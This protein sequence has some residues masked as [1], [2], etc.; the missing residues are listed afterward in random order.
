M[1]RP[2][3]LLVRVDQDRAADALE[4]LRRE[5]RVTQEAPPRLAVVEAA[6]GRAGEV[7]AVPG[8]VAVAGPGG[9]PPELTEGLSEDER[10]FVAAWELRT[11]EEGERER[12]GEGLEWDA[13][14]YTPPDP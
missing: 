13:P 11:G 2:A 9:V 7:A 10:L 4:R 3:E 14:G 8:V 1:P 12:P 6:P 5:L